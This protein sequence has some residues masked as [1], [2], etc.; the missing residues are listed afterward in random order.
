MAQTAFF[1][2]ILKFCTTNK[3]FVINLLKTIKKITLFEFPS[4][5]NLRKK[6]VAA[7]PRKEWQISK[8]H[9]VCSEHFLSDDILIASSDNHDK[10]RCNRD[11]QTS[12]RFQL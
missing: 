1:T 2:A 5:E 10:L 4:D 12:K 9:K 11:N 6:W 3:I 8:S 7:T